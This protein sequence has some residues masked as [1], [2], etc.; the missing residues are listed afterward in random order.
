[1]SQIQ[2]KKSLLI[3]L[4]IIILILLFGNIYQIFNKNQYTTSENKQFSILLNEKKS[5]EE[6][7]NLSKDKLLSLSAEIEKLENKL[8][9]STDTIKLLKNKIAS[10][11][12]IL[13]K[14]R[15]TVNERNDAKQLILDLNAKIKDLSTQ[16]DV[17]KKQNQELTLKNQQLTE[18]NNELTNNI[19]SVTEK[20]KSVASKA[21]ETNNKEA[22]SKDADNDLKSDLPI[23]ISDFSI[24]ALSNR[25]GN[26]TETSKAKNTQNISI[27]FNVDANKLAKSENKNLI[28][29]FIDPEGNTITP[30]DIET[31]T[32]N[33]KEEIVYSE[34]L[35]I[36]YQNNQPNLIKISF[37]L[38]K[39]KKG[40]Y[41]VQIYY[42]GD[43][44]SEKNIELN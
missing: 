36:N 30:N 40:T 20:Q 29:I 17:L 25:K 8:Y 3:I 32:N 16:I 27:E 37:P 34:K 2:I 1:M 39:G 15:K 22:D 43:K 23:T 26:L 35:T 28:I 24:K 4:G 42:N 18:Q 21:P 44:I 12:A 33:D 13:N 5:I 10:I 6:E 14:D 19:N 11:S 9:I 31:F 7:F 41:T 38:V